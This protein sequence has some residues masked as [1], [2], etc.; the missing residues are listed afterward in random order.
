MLPLSQFHQEHDRLSFAYLVH[1][2]IIC[3]HFVQ[4]ECHENLSWQDAGA[5]S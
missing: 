4:S 2:V 1:F 5:A 3:T